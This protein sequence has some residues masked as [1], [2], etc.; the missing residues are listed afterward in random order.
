MFS[1]IPNK[2]WVPDVITRYQGTRSCGWTEVPQMSFGCFVLCVQNPKLEPTCL[3][4]PS[5]SGMD[6]VR[7]DCV[8]VIQR[9]TP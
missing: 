4:L 6:T 3:P 1:Q 7:Q 5:L 8:P 2:I 9:P